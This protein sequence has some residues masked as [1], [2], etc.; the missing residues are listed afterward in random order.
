MMPNH[1]SHRGNTA[2]HSD[3]ILEAKA[4]FAGYGKSEILKGICLSIRSGEIVALIGPNGAGKSTLLKVIAGLLRQT[5]GSVVFSGKDITNMAVHQRAR[6]GVAF[7]VQG[8]P[9]FQSLTPSDHIQLA[10]LV[11]NQKLKRS[12]FSSGLLNSVI[13]H[14][15]RA[16]LLSG[17][18]RQALSVATMMATNPALLLCDEPSAGLAPA[19]AHDL[20][21]DIAQLA[22]QQGLPVLW[23]EQRLSDILAIADRAVLLVSGKVSAETLQPKEWLVP[24]ILSQLTLSNRTSSGNRE[25]EVTP[26]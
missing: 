9:V 4:L 16:G 21:R 26:E 10:N 11:A 1:D 25:E 3:A 8:G 6:A 19:L 13:R 22:R 20:I 2:P 5:S 18:Q 23:V 14:K 15:E 12:R 17:G 7:I 24:E